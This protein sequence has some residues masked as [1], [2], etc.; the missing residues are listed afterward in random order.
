MS[1]SADLDD[2]VAR[3]VACRLPREEW[4][5]LTHLAVG[6]WHVHRY[7]TEEALARLRAGIRRLNES[8][9]TPNSATR[10]YHETITR[11]YVG[12]LSEFLEA[13]PVEMPLAE[14]IA[15]LIASPVA[16]KD[17]LLRFYSRER[18]MSTHARAEWLEPDIMVLQVSGRVDPGARPH[19]GEDDA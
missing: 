15:R 19:G 4:T 10:G 8:H 3:F 9:G 12:L 17:V 11:A 14:R 7:G 6:M 5:H 13:C 1:L 2:V 16:D 18:L